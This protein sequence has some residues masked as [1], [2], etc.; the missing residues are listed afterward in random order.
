MKKLR[1]IMQQNRFLVLIAGA[2][3]VALIWVVVSVTIY[4]R[5]GTYLLDLSR[6]GYAPVRDRV[7]QEESYTQ[8]NFSPDGPIDEQSLQQFLKLYKERTEDIN[9]YDNFNS[10]ALHEQQLKINP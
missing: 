5:D 3:V 10:N 6:P 4:V 8:E 7:Q 1:D 9:K 2:M